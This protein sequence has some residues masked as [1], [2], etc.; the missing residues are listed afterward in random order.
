MFIILHV[1]CNFPFNDFELCHFWA[2]VAKLSA[3]VKEAHCSIQRRWFEVS[4]VFCACLVHFNLTRHEAADQTVYFSAS[5][6]PNI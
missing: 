3:E 5:F 4:G 2:S 1:I 6:S